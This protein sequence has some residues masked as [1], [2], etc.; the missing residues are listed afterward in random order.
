MYI[1]SNYYNHI[2]SYSVTVNIKVNL[3]KKLLKINIKNK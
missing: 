2:L 3:N 1:I